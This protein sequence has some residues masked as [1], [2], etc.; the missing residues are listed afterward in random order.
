VINAVTVALQTF[1]ERQIQQ[2][3]QC[4]NHSE[5]YSFVRLQTAVGQ[6]P[7]PRALHDR[8]GISLH[9]LIER[10]CAASGERRAEKRLRQ[11]EIIRD[12]LRTDVKTNKRRDQYHQHDPWL[13]KFEIVSQAPHHCGSAYGHRVG[14]GTHTE[15]CSDSPLVS[16][17]DGAASAAR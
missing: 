12:I 4:G 7:A 9:I 11:L 3:G 8:V 15:Y 1:T 13:G 10:E 16:S 2:S 6:R 14:I 5:I 17:A